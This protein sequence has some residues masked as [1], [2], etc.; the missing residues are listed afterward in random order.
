[1]TSIGLEERMEG[2]RECLYEF[3]SHLGVTVGYLLFVSLLLKGFSLPFWIG[4]LLGMNLLD[5]DH[6]L[7]VFTHLKEESS[8][9]FIRL[10]YDKKYKEAI[11]Y[12]VGS[13]KKCNRKI[14][15]NAIF[16]AAL[17]VFSILWVLISHS[18]AFQIGL[19]LSIFLH[20]LKD[21][22]DDLKDMEHLK[23]WLFWYS[24]KPVSDR[25]LIMYISFLTLMFLY[26]TFMMISRLS[27]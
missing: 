26:S 14:L 10:W 9:K 24:K 3:L 7:Y 15:H 6:L 5:L 1:M 23:K 18:S 11:F 27:V 25:V 19:I 21:I 12:I 2:K 4:G 8:Q 17:G 20:L 16:A 13:H 22:I